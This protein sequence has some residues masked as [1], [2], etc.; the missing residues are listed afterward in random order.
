MDSCFATIWGKAHEHDTQYLRVF[1]SQL[2][3]SSATIPPIRDTSS[4]SRALATA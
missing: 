1:V 3:T 2:A 4:M